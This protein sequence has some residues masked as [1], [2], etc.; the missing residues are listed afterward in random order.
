[1]KKKLLAG[2]MLI[3]FSFSA[4]AQ[5]FK[6]NGVV[7]GKADGSPLDGVTVRV[8]GTSRATQTNSEGKFEITASSGEV[9][10]FS[11]I[12]YQPAEAPA[13]ETVLQ[14]SLEQARGTLN[15]VVVTA[16]GIV[17]QKKSLGYAVQEL[18]SKDV[19]GTSEPNLINALEGKVAGVRVTN[20]QGEM[21]SSRIVIRGETSISGY[22]QPLFVVN[23]LPVDN[24]Q[25]GAGGSRD[26]ANAIADINPNDVESISFLKGPNSAALYGSRAAQGVV[27]IKT[28]TGRKRKGL[29]ITVNSNTSFSNLLTLPKYQNVFGQGASGE[30]SYKDGAGGGVNDNVDESWGPK[31]DGRMIP[32]FFDGTPQPFVPHPDNVK[33]FF[34]TGVSFNN[35]VGI[36]DAGD[37][38]SYRAS[39]NTQKMFGVIPNSDLGRNNFS[40]NTTL[41]LDPR[42]TLT[43]NIN[44]IQT[45]SG[46]LPGAGG[47]RSTS[48]MLQFIWMGRQ[49]DMNKLRDHYY[50]TLSPLNWNNA[51]YSNPFFVAEQ[52]TVS[53]RRGRVIGDVGLNYK[54]TDELSAQ[55]RSGTDY[56]TDRRKLRIAYGTSGTPFGSYEED[57]YTV[58][59]NN[60]ELTLNYKHKLNS[61][62]S[63]EVLG[64]ANL[65]TVSFEENDQKAPRLAVAGVYTLTNSRDPLVSSNYFSKR[66]VYS[67]FGSVE[68]GFRNYA[69]VNFTSRNDWS[70]T[71]P[72]ANLSYFYPSISGTFVLSDAFDIHSDVLSYAKL[73]G[74]W[75][76]V[77]AD[78]DPYQLIASY[79]FITPI[80][81]TNPMLTANTLFPNANLKPEMTTSTEIGAE[82]GFF[83]NRVRLDLSLYRSSSFNQILRAD[84]SPATGYYQKLI[85]AGRLNNKGLEV[86]LGVTA[87]KSTHFSWDINA[88]YAA[89]RSKLVELDDAGLLKNYLLGSDG[90]IQTIATVGKAYGSLFGTAFLRNSQGQVIVEDDGTPATNPTNQILGK[91]TPNWLGGIT[92]TFTFDHFSLSVLV[93]GSFGGKQYSSTNATGS[94]TGVLASTLP[95]RDAAHGGLSYYYP[96]NNSKLNPVAGTSGPAGEKIYDDGIIFQGVTRDGKSN[97]TILP[98]SAYYKTLN[99]FDEA[100]IYNSS[101]VKLR[102]VRL[103]YDVPAEWLRHI[104]FAGATVTLVGRNLWIIHKNVPNVD[105]ETAF[106]TGNGQGL[107]DLSLPG[108]RSYGINLNFKF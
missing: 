1:M 25:L 74:G 62:F 86:Q 29:G 14:V 41:K 73:R 92:N 38:Y 59:E 84:V 50:S 45:S 3:F 12:G 21:G 77:G 9:I 56:Y 57:A 20:S 78:S 7:T 81:G 53:Q 40:L 4:Q 34:K 8:K 93:D 58:N 103:G 31:M 79:P 91:Y 5:T 26:F 70:S 27:V 80:F 37:K 32:Q 24:S 104:G 22:N 102:E 11:F 105:P 52:N 17:R 35:G 43:A 55:L 18:K 69:F 108:I 16:L 65:R 106:N 66:K 98:A 61:D 48:T 76:K 97:K 96:G 23:G 107:E 46:N 101:F 13:S 83:R 87:I 75:S 95:G 82:A 44:Y 19:A 88:N 47:K 10:Q 68:L 71:L 49:V 33:S 64:G 39:V 28:K 72:T 51:Y 30:F 60:T 63:L 15:E 94:Y 36:E 90:T 42:L 89:N 100:W 6:V 2:L 67:L 54:I 99:N 85:N